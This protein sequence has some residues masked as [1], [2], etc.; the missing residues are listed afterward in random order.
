M[1]FIRFGGL[2]G[3]IP[4][5]PSL[6]AKQVH[7]LVRAFGAPIKRYVIAEG[8]LPVW[9]HVYNTLGINATAIKCRNAFTPDVFDTVEQLS[10]VLVLEHSAPKLLPQTFK[11][12]APLPL[13][14]D[15]K[16]VRYILDNAV[17]FVHM[18]NK[19]NV[20]NHFVAGIIADK[21][22]ASR[23][24]VFDSNG[25]LIDVDW[26]QPD[27]VLVDVLPYPKYTQHAMHF[28]VYVKEEYLHRIMS[29]KE[30]NDTNDALAVFY[31][32]GM[33]CQVADSDELNYIK[34]YIS[35]VANTDHVF[36]KCH[37][38]M[39]KTLKG[40]AAA[41]CYLKPNKNDPFLAE[42]NNDVSLCLSK[43]YRVMVLGHSHGGMMA[44]LVAESF[45]QNKS[46]LWKQKYKS[47]LQFLTFGSIYTPDAKTVGEDI[48]IR[49]YMFLDDVAMRCNKL[50]QPKEK[51]LNNQHG[52]VVWMKHDTIKLKRWEKL[53]PAGTKQ[54]WEIHNAYSSIEKH[55]LARIA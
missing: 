37:P 48:D 25:F 6:D 49:H 36:I 14:V 29:A 5:F 30:V 38:S 53:A 41:A 26:T 21:D 3:S 24:F 52:N 19:L 20:E 28:V 8:G 45:A 44:S 46:S 16:G 47:K 51:H 27:T 35:N 11:L 32:L 10:D 34:K 39:T 42:I 9:R 54:S 2:R 55:I 31:V 15:I 4:P 12:D 1:T 43:G 17:M 23:P 50:K 22:C 18:K 40:I 7:G 13:H 33:G